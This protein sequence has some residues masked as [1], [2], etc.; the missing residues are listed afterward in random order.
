[1]LAGAQAVAVDDRATSS[2]GAQS[3]LF[4]LLTYTVTVAG[5]FGVMA[6]VGGAGDGNHTL[7]DY[8]GLSSARPML[9]GLM[10]VLLFAQAGIP[11]TSGFFAK[12]RIILAAADSG[13]YVLAGIAMLSA[14]VAAVLYL[15]IVVSMFL[16]GAPAVALA[17]T[18]TDTE[19]DD[20]A[21]TDAPDEADSDAAD[22][23]EPVGRHPVRV[24]TPAR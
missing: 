21:G 4:Y 10:A 5:T 16:T 20:D 11:F 2:L 6:V 13:S 23:V 15:R 17:A 22:E 7:D 24:A 3:L 1:M 12:F 14:V 9:A 8:R 18:D 19:T